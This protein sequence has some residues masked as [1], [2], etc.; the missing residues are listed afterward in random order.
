LISS[1]AQTLHIFFATEYY[2]EKKYLQNKLSEI[3]FQMQ[4]NFYYKNITKNKG[5]NM[6]F[7]LQAFI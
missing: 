7:V 4:S 1:E 2:F 6:L 3:C 5:N